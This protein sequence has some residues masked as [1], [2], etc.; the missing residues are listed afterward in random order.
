MIAMRKGFAIRYYAP[1]MTART[2]KLIGTV[3]LLVFLA[4]YAFAAAAIG[5]SRVTLAPHWAQLAYFVAAG[6]AWVVPAA[7]LIRW[8]HR[9]D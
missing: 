8:M 6:L 4:L 2:R 7:L 1:V 9:P 5:A 3:V